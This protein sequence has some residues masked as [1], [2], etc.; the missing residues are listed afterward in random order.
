MP[1]DYGSRHPNNIEH[2]SLDEQDTIGFDT[3]REVYVRNI[4]CLDNSP[5]YVR[6]EQKEMAAE[7]DAYQEAREAL[8]KRNIKAPQNSPYGKIWQQLTVIGKLM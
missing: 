4:I 3:G 2:L 6:M 1:C 7:R 8:M 5:N